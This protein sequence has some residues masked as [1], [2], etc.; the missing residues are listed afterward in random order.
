[1]I[2]RPLLFAVMALLGFSI[3]LSY[4]LPIY[5]VVFF[6]CESNHFL[7]RQSIAVGVG[8]LMIIALSWLNPDRWFNRIGLF[9]FLFFFL[10]LIMMQFLPSS[11]V[12]A[13][14]G[15]KRWIRLGSFSIAPVEFFKIGFV[16]FLAWSF[17]RKLLDRDTM[18]FKEEIKVF[19]P[20]IIVFFVAVLLIAILQKDLGQVVVLG[21]TL[22]VL[23]LFA[24]SSFKFFMTLLGSA[25]VGM[26]ALILSAPHRIERVASWWGSVQDKVLVI[27]PF[28]VVQELKVEAT[29][30]PYQISNSLNAI[31]HG[32]FLGQGLS[33]GQFE[34]GYLSEI[35]TDFVLAGVA[36]EFGF[37]G[38]LA[39]SGLL[40]FIIYRIFKIA[41][42]VQNPTHYLFSVGVGLIIALSFIIN[43]FGI[44]GLFPIKGIA[45]PFLSY[46]GS[47]IIAS[48]FAIGLILMISKNRVA[49]E[50]IDQKLL[51]ELRQSKEEKTLN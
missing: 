9:V 10:L 40:L 19:F 5:T 51:E 47:H 16:F 21:G 48:S 8:F 49:K 11:Y 36:E 7:L 14:S 50:E 22:A 25:L 35:H 17:S 42:L 3:I 33:S 37:V 12:N 30:E 23:F 32:G 20:Y 34:L 38:I 15:A 27:F 1:M 6:E 31:H 43:S 45:V 24:G 28:E 44:S 26:G 46:G 2:D 18:S 4:A 13:V 29:Q 39:V 41:A